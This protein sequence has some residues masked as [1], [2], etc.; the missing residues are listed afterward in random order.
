MMLR[1]SY[2]IIANNGGTC[3]YTCGTGSYS[4]PCSY[5]DVRLKKGIETLRN[6]LEKLIQL[7]TV[8]YDWNE[9]IGEKDYENFKRQG[10]LH[11]IGLI[12]QD[13]RDYFPEVVEISKEG[14]YYVEYSKLNAVLVEAIKQQQLFID[15][16]LEDL[17]LLE[18]H[19][20]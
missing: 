20:N 8:T 7:E 15:D 12:A 4:G 2:I 11:S 1:K 5:S 10:K 16:I 13:V 17:K 18:S 19:V 14:Y 6:S 3:F 9:K